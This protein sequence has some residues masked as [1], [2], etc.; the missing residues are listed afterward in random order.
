MQID[1]LCRAIFS[2]FYNIWLANCAV[3]LIL[4]SSFRKFLFLFPNQKLV[5]SARCLLQKWS[6]QLKNCIKAYLVAPIK[7][8]FWQARKDR[9]PVNIILLPSLPS[10]GPL[11][12]HH[13]KFSNN[14]LRYRM[15]FP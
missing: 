6:L 15:S 10:T 12:C 3:W 2:L 11:F 1:I 7:G 14:V 9:Y 8:L 4:L 13:L 5:F